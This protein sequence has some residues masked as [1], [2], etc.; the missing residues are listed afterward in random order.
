MNSSSGATLDWGDVFEALA[1]G[2][3]FPLQDL[4]GY[5]KDY[6]VQW[7]R[8]VSSE[9][10]SETADSL[11][12]LQKRPGRDRHEYTVVHRHPTGDGKSSVVTIAVPGRGGESDKPVPVIASEDEDDAPRLVFEILYAQQVNTS[13]V[14]PTFTIGLF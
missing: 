6:A 8:G 5:S 3:R 9:F 2:G 10:R 1:T 7:L 13:H 11:R 12:E 4:R 14:H